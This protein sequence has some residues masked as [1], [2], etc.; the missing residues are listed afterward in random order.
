MRGALYLE[1]NANWG[2][3][4]IFNRA[5]IVTDSI[6]QD[7]KVMTVLP[8]S[9]SD[10]AGVRIGDVITQIDGHTPSKDPLEQNYPAFLQ[11]V[12]AIV[13]VTVKRGNQ[14]RKFKV[15]LADMF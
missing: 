2:K 7:Q 8:G 4:R 6:I 5:G 15:V 11:P 10:I 12:G 13:H 9:P 1:K 14:V 3:P